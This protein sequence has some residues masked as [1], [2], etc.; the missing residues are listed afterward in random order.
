MTARLRWL[1]LA[2]G[3]LVAAVVL[4]VGI[5][6]Y[7]F[8]QPGPLAGPAIIVVPK[9]ASVS[10]IARLLKRNG[11]L[12]SALVF[13]AGVRLAGEAHHLQAG[14]YQF[15]GRVSARDAMEILKSGKTLVRH[16]TV[17]EG[18]TVVQV[19]RL[20]IAAYGL[21]GPVGPMPEEGALLPDTYNYSY[22]DT[23]RAMLMRM[24]SAMSET[25]ARLWRGRDQNI[26]ITSPADAVILASIVEKETGKAG[27]RPL[28]AGV[29]YNRL[30]RGM[31]LQS[32]P[33]VAYAVALKEGAPGRVLGR[34]LTREDLEQ[35][36]PYN[37]YLNRGLPPGPIANPG[38]ASLK[39]VLHPAQTDALYFVADGDGG[40]V[41]AKTL[42]EHIR[43]VRHWRELRKKQKEMA[44]ED[45]HD[46]APAV[47]RSP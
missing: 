24:E 31:P 38:R 32:D 35:P 17:P 22:G 27:E 10:S 37:T 19:V 47:P 25:V 39:A 21:E 33:T 18:L 1:A 12:K 26:P 29:F 13:D 6:F 34:P 9:G 23:R 28:I 36:S 14:E 3:A 2:A 7:L 44:P 46:G 41:F 4:L 20:V 30:R 42:K 5:L 11:L 40:H 43:N 8:D 45:D 16:L 15:P